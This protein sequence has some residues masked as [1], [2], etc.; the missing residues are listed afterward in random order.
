MMRRRRFLG[1]VLT[2]GAST[3]AAAMWIPS[4]AADDYPS[5]VI[6]SVCM[7]APGSSCRFRPADRPTWWRGRSRNSSASG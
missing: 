6:T 2:I 3:L 1:H 5:K 4:A 7:F